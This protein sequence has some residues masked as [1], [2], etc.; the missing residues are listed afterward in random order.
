MTDKKRPAW[1]TEHRCPSCEAFRRLHG[2]DRFCMGTS[3]LSP[4]PCGSKKTEPAP[5]GGH[6]A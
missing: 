4:Y 6:S 3:M 2:I 5:A 1:E